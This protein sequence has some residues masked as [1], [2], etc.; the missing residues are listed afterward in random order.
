MALI[1][2]RV[3]VD[4]QYE[5][6]IATGKQALSDGQVDCAEAKK[7]LDWYGQR[8]PELDLLKREI[9]LE[10]RQI[11]NDFRVKIAQATVR[12]D[13]TKFR[14]AQTLELAP[15]AELLEKIERLAIEGEKLKPTLEQF[16]KK[17]CGG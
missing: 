4:H 11:R 16:I 5:R 15:Y 8:K 12:G 6:W 3:K 2:L 9:N 14:N 10:M 13:K 7:W 17:E 1:E